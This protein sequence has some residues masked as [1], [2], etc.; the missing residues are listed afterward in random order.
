MNTI[1]TIVPIFLVILVGFVIKKK[2]LIPE[3]FL[4]PA[5]KL[6]Y[7]IA[8]PAMIFSA[9]VRGNFF[10]HFDQ[11]LLIGTLIPLFI[12]LLIGWILSM[13]IK[14]PRDQRG[15]FLDTAIHGNIGY[16]GLA[17]VFYYLGKTALTAA[18]VLAGFLMLT[19]NSLAVIVLLANAPK[20]PGKKPFKQILAGILGNPI[21]ATSAAGI[22]FS[23]LSLHLPVI[24]ERTLGII[25]NLALP[26]ALLV[27]GASLSFR[28]ERK[29]MIY[30]L[31]S[32]FFKLILLP[33]LGIWMYSLF[34]IPPA[35]Y[36]PGLILLSAPV[37]TVSSIMASE[38]R[39]DPI[40]AANTVS[41]STALSLITYSMWLHLVV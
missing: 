5:N 41:L 32:C 11:W 28:Y 36:L 16:I 9:I 19:H 1:N 27:I 40:M 4:A 18:S 14:V 39:G 23:V 34:G 35:L 25:G 24:L 22:L 8:I 21:I 31:I 37:A 12:L 30:I 29:Q 15:T 20:Q 10:D 7:Y 38:M 2:G 17:V 13:L 26:L 33:A 3:G 6:T